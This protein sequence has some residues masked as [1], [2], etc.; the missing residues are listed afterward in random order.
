MEVAQPFESCVMEDPY[1]KPDFWI[2]RLVALNTKHASI[3]AT[4]RKDDFQLNSHIMHRLL[5][6]TYID[7]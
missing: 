1:E 5:Q 6:E 4:Y 7:L 2:V 3:A